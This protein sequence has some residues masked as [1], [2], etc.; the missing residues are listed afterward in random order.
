MP[1]QDKA[2]PL[3][4]TERILQGI[5]YFLGCFDNA[6]YKFLSNVKFS[7]PSKQVGKL[8]LLTMDID[9]REW[10]LLI[11]TFTQKHAITPLPTLI[12]EKIFNYFLVWMEEKLSMKN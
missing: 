9:G 8:N 12:Y 1:F 7:Y 11:S 3:L 4:F 5:Y 10:D 6:Q 2:T